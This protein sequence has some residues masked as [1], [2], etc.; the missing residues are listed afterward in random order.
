MIHFQSF[1][2]LRCCL[3]LSLFIQGYAFAQWEIL[4]SYPGLGKDDAV[5]FSIGN[6]GYLATGNNAG[7]EESNFVFRYSVSE[8]S[9][10]RIS[11]F[12]GPT[13]QYAGRFVIND[14]GVIDKK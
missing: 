10:T 9:W 8:N 12:A 4:P 7:F 11:D 3:F 6:Y 5:A 14:F 1:C 13:R 2:I